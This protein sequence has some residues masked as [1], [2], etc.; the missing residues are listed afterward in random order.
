MST[1][2]ETE[3]FAGKTIQAWK[4][5]ATKAG[6]VLRAPADVTEPGDFPDNIYSSLRRFR[7]NIAITK[8]HKKIVTR[9]TRQL[10]SERDQNGKPL[11]ILQIWLPFFHV[12]CFKSTFI[13]LFQLLR[14]TATAF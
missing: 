6:L 5:Q 7:R 2:L 4:D 10:V 8:D 11:L 1:K 12:G 13:S 9:M 14:N 3:T